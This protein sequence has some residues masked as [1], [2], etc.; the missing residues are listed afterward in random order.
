[1][2]LGRHALAPLCCA[3]LLESDPVVQLKLSA[4]VRDSMKQCAAVHGD[5]F[6]AAVTRLDP[7]ISQQLQAMLAAA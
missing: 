6:Q 5:T 7:A 2:G 1:M 3:Q 4:V